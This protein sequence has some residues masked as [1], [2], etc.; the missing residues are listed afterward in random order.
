MF[1]YCVCVHTHARV[2]VHA[3][4]HIH[5]SI[6]AA[7]RELAGTGSDLLYVGPWD[8]THMVRPVTSIST[9]WE[10]SLT[11]GCLLTA[12]RTFSY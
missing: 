10:M 12:M 6:F 1:N 2:C 8:Q 4:L 3:R 5:Y 7:V 9:S 11:S